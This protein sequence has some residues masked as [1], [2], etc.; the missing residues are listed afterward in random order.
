MIDL[1]QQFEIPPVRTITDHLAN[2]WKETYGK[3]DQI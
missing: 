1:T 2:D 3:H